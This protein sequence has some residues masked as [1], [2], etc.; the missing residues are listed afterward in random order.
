MNK[1]KID[2]ILQLIKNDKAQENHLFKT[3]STTENPFPLLKPLKKAGYFDPENNP[4]PIEV[5]NQKGYFTIPH[6]NVLNYLENVAEKSKN[7]PSTEISNILEDIINNIINYRTED[8]ERID[9]YRTDWILAKIIF[10]LPL[11]N[12]QEQH[13]DF[14]R[15]VLQSKWET[16]L[17][18]SEI[19]KSIIPA[20]LDKDSKDLLLNVL[21]IVFDYKESDIKSSDKYESLVE[22]YWLKE[23]IQ[24]H[25]GS[26]IK[27]CGKDA[28]DIA[29][30]KIEKM[31]EEDK[32]QFN[33]IWIPTIEDHA[34]TSFPDRYECQ[35]V[36]FIR[37][38]YQALDSREI[39]EKI[40]WL[41]GQEHPIFYRLAIHTINYHFEDLS[42]L[43][44]SWKDN[45]L[46]IYGLKHELYELLKCNC[47]SFDKV[48]IGK[49]INWIDNKEYYISEEY[50]DDIKIK[51]NILA[52]RKKEWLSSLLEAN[53]DRIKSLYS[54]YDSI[55]PA[56]LDHPGFDSWSESSWGSE[57][58]I[59]E[60][61]LLSKKNDEIVKYLNDFKESDG[62][63][64]PS[65][66]GLTGVL[67]KCVSEN[68]EKFTEDISVYLELKR[69][70]QQALLWGI[71]EA[72][73]SNKPVDW[74]ALFI[75]IHG[76]LKSKDFWEERYLEN[77]YNY[78]NWIIAQIADLINDGTRNDQHAFDPE[79]LSEAEA[80]L[81]LLVERSESNHHE[82]HDIVTSVL[83]SNRGKIFT[84]MINYSLRNARINRKEDTYK[85]IESIKKD[86]TKRLD[87]DIEPSLD[88]SV[89]IGEYLPNLY[90]LDKEWVI[91]NINQIFPI[92]KPEYWKASFTGYLLYA[93]TVYS[94][95][96]KLLSEN[97]HYKKALSI[98]F[99][100]DH[101]RDRIAQHI[102]VAY[103]EGWEN[104]EDK[105]SQINLLLNSK[106]EKNL[107]A[108]INFFRMQRKIITEKVKSCIKPLWEQL[109]TRIE[110]KKENEEYK[111]LL[112]DTS[113]FLSL[114]DTIDNDIL[115]WLK[116]SAQY[117]NKNYNSPFFIESLLKHANQSPKEVAELLLEI[118]N[119]GFFPDYKKENIAEIIRIISDGET[120]DSAIRICNLYLNKG[121]DFTRPI[122]QEI[123]LKHN[124]TNAEVT[125]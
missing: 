30:D 1:E 35:I 6:W 9:N 87:R 37:D 45:P 94:D 34:Q 86:F 122:L 102:C 109:F 113:K 67:K 116:L 71:S 63:K 15:T 7:E 46:E 64:G 11:K 74:N 61:E 98:E 68:P 88:F 48:Q 28:S 97:G 29:L 55:N 114:I 90:Y 12:I 21:D 118:L 103:L 123:K 91:E 50:K 36:Y 79:I 101:V 56:E 120:K 108:I 14:L 4:G 99:K 119:S 17:I 54:K 42:S 121:F 22:S 125:P 66:E 33:N 78:R 112:S 59:E 75:F 92:D 95:L 26:I 77:S 124:E 32:N 73:R 93:S 44:W 25:K 52:Y 24:K 82:I 31:V 80:I 60:V 83:N 72:W 47:K 10:F 65:I 3:L 53:N 76:I 117:I 51:E 27:T 8:S 23:T 89:V 70:Y 104:L 18:S 85:W 49:I 106:N 40:S 96:Y 5:A 111:K 57:S 39:S 58:P 110:E 62:W 69:V 81:F 107:S 105:D 20:I 115:G 38:C 100:D 43:F 84:A 2:K 16:S 41:L 13:I 19:G